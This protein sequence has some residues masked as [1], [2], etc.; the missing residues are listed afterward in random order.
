[1]KTPGPKKIEI[2]CP[3]CGRESWL[4]RKT[5]YEGFTAVGEILSC[6]LCS[7][8]FGSEEEIDFIGSRTPQVFTEVDRPRAVKIFNEDEKGRM[9]R[10]CAEYVINPFLQRCALHHC[11]VEATDTCPHFRAKPPPELGEDP[12]IPKPFS[13]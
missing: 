2:Q 5:K 10:Y 11:E 3:A 12:E 13:L 9:C 1:M 8:E 4:S 7:H 6:A